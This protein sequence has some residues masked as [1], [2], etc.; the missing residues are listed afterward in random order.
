[1]G[2][3]WLLAGSSG[4]VLAALIPAL[5][6]LLWL[7]AVG[8][9]SLVLL[10]WAQTRLLAVFL[11]AAVWF[12]L[13][14]SWQFDRSWPAS[15]A[16]EI[17]QRDIRVVSL[18]EWRGDSVQFIA[19][20]DDASDGPDGR[21][22]IRW[23]RP[24]DYIQPGQHWRVQLRM[25]PPRGRLNA[26]GFDY[27]RYLLSQR[28]AGLG[29]IRQAELLDAGRA[30]QGMINQGRQ[31][32]A[33]VLSAESQSLRAASLMR[34]LAI[35]DRSAMDD[36]TRDLLAVTGTAHLLA[37]SGLHVGMI[38]MLAGA[39]ASLLAGPLMLLFPGLDRRRFA[40]V[41][42]LVAA[43]GYALL[44]G[45][46]L[47]TQRA[48]IMLAV[49]A[50]AFLVRRGLQPGHALLVAFASVLLID[51]LAVLATGFWMSFAAVGVLI[52]TF[53]WRPS[54][55]RGVIHWAAGLL[56]AQLMIGVGLIALNAG[57]FNQV[58]WFG[59]PANL[60]A[61]PLV[62]FWV[63]PSLLLS[64]L[65]IAMDWPATWFIWLCESGIELLLHYLEWLKSIGPVSVSRPPVSLLA[66]VLGVL[67]S[68]WLIGPSAWPAR[69]LGLALLLPVFF[70]SQR[71]PI[72]PGELE[73]H[74]LDV[75]QGQ[76]ALI[77]TQSG[78][79]LYDTG[80]GDGEGGD[81]LGRILPAVL[82]AQGQLP[83]GRIVVSSSHVGSRG[84]LG[85]VMDLAPE[86]ALYSPLPD[87][88]QP[89]TA[90]EG[91]QT[92]D[93][94]F[95]FLHPARGLPDLGP[96]S[97]CVLRVEGPGGAIVLS[98]RIDAAVE[99]RLVE[100]GGDL[101][102]DVLVLADGG[103]RRASGADFLDA[104][105]PALALASTE[106]HDRFDRPHQDVVQR[107]IDRGIEFQSTG[108]CGSLRVRL[109]PE[110]GIRVQS[111]VG[112]SHR[113]WHAGSDC[114]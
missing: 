67:G 25:L 54:R 11:L 49:V 12:L 110:A 45:L 112:R 55:G 4:V 60:V 92:D 69:W 8:A 32:L 113:F 68:L 95:E 3:R 85:S 2:W 15:R 82:A 30:G 43:L 48:L 88:G 53:A 97:S 78:W 107:L 44:A 102:A 41:I 93:Y 71:D 83:L 7:C 13:Q 56:R 111:A 31:Y 89:C 80:P 29:T 19:T 101:A 27:T 98:G 1:M 104:V 94:R 24:S 70:P 76:A 23:F 17:V 58:Q 6:G 28:I 86:S 81:A 114:P 50:G 74:L 87:L 22:L 65:M 79:M 52:W 59:F 84:G 62:G 66:I 9:L 10:R 39:V 33:E 34:A 57:V 20:V 106:R 61:I 42:A 37:I 14:A 108:D 38:A 75:G 21:L 91:W 63:L 26:Q 109:S 100:F 35:A 5:P 90:G 47:P 105:Q 96:N 18:P 40:L 99:R 73:L 72:G 103:H 64:M 77:G 46:T 51:P 36:E 16:G